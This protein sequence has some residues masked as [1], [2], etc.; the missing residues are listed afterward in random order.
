MLVAPFIS[1][2][3]TAAFIEYCLSSCHSGQWQIPMKSPHTHK[4]RARGV[5]TLKHIEWPQEFSM[6]MQQTN[7]SVKNL[8]YFLLKSNFYFAF[9]VAVIKFD[10]TSVCRLNFLPYSVVLGGLTVLALTFGR[11]AA[12]NWYQL[13]AAQRWFCVGFSIIFSFRS[14]PRCLYVWMCALITLHSSMG[15][16][17]LKLEP[18]I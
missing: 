3:K 15:W 8:C 13:L 9:V 2:R 4:D 18:D 17:P 6:C 10:L 14:T 16:S 5:H 1:S 11:A 7:L 12:A